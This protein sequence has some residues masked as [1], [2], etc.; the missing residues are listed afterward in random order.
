MTTAP[1]IAPLDLRPL[2]LRRLPVPWI[3]LT[4]TPPQPQHRYSRM[5]ADGLQL[6]RACAE[7][8]QRT[9]ARRERE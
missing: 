7:A 5:T 3:W 1:A 2:P 4:G 6:A 8:F 9:A